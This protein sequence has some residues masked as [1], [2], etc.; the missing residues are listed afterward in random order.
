MN[1]NNNNTDDNNNTDENDYNNDNNYNDYILRVSNNNQ[2]FQNLYDNTKNNKDLKI[3]SLLNSNIITNSMIYNNNLYDN[4]SNINVKNKKENK[5]LFSGNNLIEHEIDNNNDKNSNNSSL[6][7]TKFPIINFRQK[8]LKKYVFCTKIFCKRRCCIK[9]SD[10]H[11][12][13]N[14][15]NFLFD[16]IHFLKTK[17]EVNL[18]KNEIYNYEQR[19]ALNTMYTFDSDFYHEK[20]AYDLIIIKHKN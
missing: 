19:K 10:I 15:I 11:K 4:N 12:N 13:F 1:N 16:L 20:L 9:V 6:M 17:N 18:L 14:Q 8:R 7:E 5:S 3:S 2:F